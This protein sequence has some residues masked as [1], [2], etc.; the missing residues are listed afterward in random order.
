MSELPVPSVPLLNEVEKT[1][2]LTTVPPTVSATP[3]MQQ[4]THLYQLVMF[5]TEDVHLE[6]M[7]DA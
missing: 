4:S 1:V 2:P 3:A 6:R 5:T 7:R